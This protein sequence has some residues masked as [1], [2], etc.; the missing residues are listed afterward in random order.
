M[1]TKEEGAAAIQK[2]NG[3][4]LGGRALKV[5]EAKPRENRAGFLVKSTIATRK[6]I[7]G[8]KRRQI[9]F[10][11]NV[12]SQPASWASLAVPARAIR[13]SRP[14]LR[15]KAAPKASTTQW[16]ITCRRASY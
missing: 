8:F 13:F 12:S 2:L 14:H 16:C 9:F 5:N 6:R 4:E 1:S 11:T 15:P 10:L 7:S 3:Q